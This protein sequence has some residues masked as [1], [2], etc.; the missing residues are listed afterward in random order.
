MPLSPALCARIV[1]SVTGLADGYDMGSISGA[2]VL[3]REELALSSS[4]VGAIVGIAYIAMAAGAPLGGA[5]ADAIGRKKA[6]AISYAMLIAGSLL[7]AMATSFAHLFVARALLGLGIG[8][9]FAVVSTYMSEVSPKSMRGCFVGLEDLFLVAGIA[10]GY[11]MNFLLTGVPYDWRWMQGLGAICPMVALG[12]LLLP[13]LPESPRWEMLHGRRE[14]AL[15][16]LTALVGK[17]EAHSLIVD[18]TEAPAPCTWSELLNPKGA[19]RRRALVASVG[20][21]VISMLSGVAVV[22]VYMGQ[23]LAEEVPARQ[24]FL[25]TALLAV[26]RVAVIAYVV[27]WMMDIAGRR[28]LSLVSCGGV[29]VALAAMAL[30]YQMHAKVMPWKFCAFLCYYVA[31]SIGLA[32]VPFV[33]STEALPTDMRSKGVSLGILVA[34][35]SAGVV[36]WCFPLAKDAFGIHAVFAALA[37]VN[38]GSLVFLW[39]CA[40][41]T[42]GISL[43]EVHHIFRR[44]EERKNSPNWSGDARFRF[45]LTY[46]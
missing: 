37:L 36:T 3:F 45:R 21:T 40:P 43:E 46:T 5:L 27:F 16:S 35:I 15:E 25:L 2:L 10:A 20:M 1:T 34:R 26:I 28:F 24:G 8:E 41:E 17:E 32:A 13:Q 23:I 9:G 19:W 6:L 7:G 22:T 31:Y 44:G 11:W 29:A 4:Q 33:Y 12:F 14:H 30:A 39:L 42:A 38:F 18:W